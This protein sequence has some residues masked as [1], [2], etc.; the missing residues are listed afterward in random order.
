M[1][2]HVYVMHVKVGVSAIL[3]VKIQ[4]C[5]FHLAEGQVLVTS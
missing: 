4:I 2:K 3:I 1:D 5:E